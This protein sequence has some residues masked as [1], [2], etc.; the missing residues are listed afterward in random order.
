LVLIVLFII[1]RGQRKPSEPMSPVPQSSI[2]TGTPINNVDPTSGKP[3]VAGI[4][5]TYR[6]YTIG[7]CCEVSKRE[8]E[9]LS[10][11]Q[12]DTAIRQFLR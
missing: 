8:F 1:P 2:A 4:T 10:P 12:K 11:S 7:H 3:I 6:G 9:A 5:S